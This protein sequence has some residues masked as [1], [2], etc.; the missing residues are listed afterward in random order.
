MAVSSILDNSARERHDEIPPFHSITS[1]ASREQVRRNGE[2][3]R[4]KARHELK[5]YEDILRIATTVLGER[6]Q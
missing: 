6:R 3:E 1:S 5:R 2:A 4:R